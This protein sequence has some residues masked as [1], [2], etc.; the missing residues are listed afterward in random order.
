MKKRL[1]VVLMILTFTAN[2]II[3]CT[4]AN[5]EQLTP[6]TCDTANMKYSTDV[7]RIL[8]DNCYSCHG[9]GN[10]AGSGGILL[11]GYG[12]INHYV[13]AGTVRGVIT[14]APGYIGMPYERQKLDDCTINKILD[15]INQGAPNN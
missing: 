12:N 14:H 2:C 15:W 13:V 7:V 6:T 4:N 8:Q 9:N 11:E 1:F 3:S 10:T 5:K